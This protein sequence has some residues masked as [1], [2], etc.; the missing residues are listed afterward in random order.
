M[1]M[2]FK[3]IKDWATSITAFRSGDVIPVDGP[4]GN[5]K[6]GKDD[7]LKVTAENAV[8]RRQTSTISFGDTSYNGNAINL[9]S[10]VDDEDTYFVIE[11]K[12]SSVDRVM[13]FTSG[14]GSLGQKNIPYAANGFAYKIP[15][16]TAI[17][18]FHRITTGAVAD[19]TLTMYQGLSYNIVKS[20]EDCS[21]NA[22]AISAARTLIDNEMLQFIPYTKRTG[23]LRADGTYASNLTSLVTD[24]I[25]TTAGEEFL[26]QGCGEFQAISALWYNGNTILSSD[27]VWCYPNFVKLTAPASATHVIF[28][29]YSQTNSPKMCV[30]RMNTQTFG[31]VDAVEHFKSTEYM[32][33]TEGN[34]YLLQNGTFNSSP[35]THYLY[36]DIDVVPGETYLYRGHGEFLAYSVVFFDSA[37]TAVSSLRINSPNKF[38]EV[39]VPSYAVK[40]RFSSYND[41]AKPI[42]L[43]LVKKGTQA[44]R[45][46]DSTSN[47]T[48]FHSQ[49]WYAVGDSLTDY[50]TLENQDDKKNYFDFVCDWLGLD[51]FNLGRGGTGYKAAGVYNK[52][53]ERVASIPASAKLVTVFGSFNDFNNDIS[54]I[55]TFGDTTDATCYGAM[56]KFFDALFTKCES[57]ICGV[58]TPTKWGYLNGS[59]IG[60][61]NTFCD[62]YVEALKKTAAWFGCPVLDLYNDSG[63]RPWDSTFVSDCYLESNGVHPLSNAHK[64]Y[65]APKVANFIRMIYK[66]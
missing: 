23:F 48:I 40:M 49:K 65:I 10:V 26:Y 51:G 27:K 33:F 61:T 62:Q 42:E 11:N 17:L 32:E 5:A 3:R 37:G 25:A 31:I 35:T 38:V 44:C 18:Q 43:E 41:A 9:S 8:G 50:H 53:Y 19:A 52:F 63:L 20:V 34:G 66:P 12:Q 6:M 1:S 36:K 60:Q 7:L 39:V 4:S 46:L 64:Q 47:D 57:V 54:T 30:V 13:F 15:S 56:Y 14:W 2:L 29:S 58:I 16:G 28:S 45:L 59:T 22:T 24:K 21:D 55:G